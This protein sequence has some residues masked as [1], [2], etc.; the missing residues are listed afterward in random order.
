MSRLFV[1][2]NN[3]MPLAYQG[4]QAGH[5]VAQ[6]LIEH[7]NQTWNNNYLI[8]LGV[9]EKELHRWVTKLKYKNDDYSIFK[10]PDLD[11]KITAIACLA[12]DKNIF[13]KLKLMGT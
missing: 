6:W 10:E 9:S 7:P 4:V 8:Y 3:E 2:V 1:L 12:D 13:K 11:N 5:A